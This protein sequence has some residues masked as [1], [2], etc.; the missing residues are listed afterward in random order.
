MS[1]QTGNEKEVDLMEDVRV[2]VETD[3]G[4]L[5]CQILTIF[6]AGDRDYIALYPVDEND[7]LLPEA[8]ILLYRYAEDAEGNPSIDNIES[9][10]EYATVL[11]VFEGLPSED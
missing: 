8:D 9:D 6:T 2:T 4:E 7:E 11:E 10:E 3:E 5:E 1:E